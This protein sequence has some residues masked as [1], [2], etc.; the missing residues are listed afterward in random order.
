MAF[1]LKKHAE[2]NPKSPENNLIDNRDERGWHTETDPGNIDWMLSKNRKNKDNTVL[3]QGQLEEARTGTYEET[4]EASM[5]SAK[6]GYNERRLSKYWDVDAKPLDILAEAF[7]QEK[8]KAFRQAQKGDQDKT[9]LQ[10]N[11]VGQQL[12]EKR[13]RVPKNVPEQ[14]S[15]L[16]NQPSRMKGLDKTYPVS[17]DRA[18]NDKAQNKK[19]KIPEMIMASLKDADAMIFHVY[20]VAANAGRDLNEQEIKI[21]AEIEDGKK[22]IFAEWGE[23]DAVAYE[24]DD[25]EEFGRNESFE[26]AMAE[27]RDG[28]EQEEADEEGEVEDEAKSAI[29]GPMTPSAVIPIDELEFSMPGE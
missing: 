6:K 24:P 5:D 1:N 17:V 19:D 7:F 26:D 18:D 14:G 27:M 13:T 22:K 11:S 2:D 4:T 16:H 15:Q 29:A 8:L 23:E 20:A 9:P 10:S 25:L 28:E 21:L 3:Y 12:D